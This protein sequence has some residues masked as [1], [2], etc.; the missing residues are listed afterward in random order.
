MCDKHLVQQRNMGGRLG[1]GRRKLDQD[2]KK[3][4]THGSLESV[5]VPRR[6]MGKRMG[7]RRSISNRGQLLS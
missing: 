3:G 7:E 1:E 5:E 2:P 4:E 6:G